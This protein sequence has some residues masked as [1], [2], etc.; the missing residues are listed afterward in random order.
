MCRE[1]LVRRKLMQ[2]LRELF[3]RKRK[4]LSQCEALGGLLGREDISKVLYHQ[5]YLLV[6]TR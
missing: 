2:V 5:F 4:G 3:G 1:S 6:G